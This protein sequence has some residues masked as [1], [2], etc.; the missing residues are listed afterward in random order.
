MRATTDCRP[1]SIAGT[2][3]IMAG[4]PTY[5]ALSDAERDW[6][7][8]HIAYAHSIGVDPGNEASISDFFDSTLD[9]VNSGRESPEV[10]NTVVNVVGVLIG[11]LICAQSSLG[12]AIVTDEHGTDLCLHDPAMSW[13]LFPQSSAAKRWEAKETG[14]VK[15]FC[16]WARESVS[17]PPR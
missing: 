16:A 3:S 7:E 8:R 13:T 12:W 11:E 6:I 9:A 5:A 1:Q 10:A 4:K 2:I 17:A 14:W 15:P